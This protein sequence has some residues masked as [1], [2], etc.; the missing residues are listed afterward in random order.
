MVQVHHAQSLSKIENRLGTS[1]EAVLRDLEG[2][3]PKS[4]RAPASAPPARRTKTPRDSVETVDVS[5]GNT[6]EEDEADDADRLLRDLSEGD[7][8]KEGGKAAQAQA[9]LW[10]RSWGL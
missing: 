9:P 3:K 5:T 1:C 10:A 2:E 7:E 8:G 6:D 4:R